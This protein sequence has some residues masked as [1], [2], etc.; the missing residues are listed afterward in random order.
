MIAELFGSCCYELVV[1]SDSL[2][3]GFELRLNFHNDVSDV[4]VQAFSCFEVFVK[5]EST[6]VVCC[7]QCVLEALFSWQC[8]DV[9]VEAFSTVEILFALEEFCSFMRLF[10]LG[11]S[12]ALYSRFVAQFDESSTVQLKDCVVTCMAQRFV[13]VK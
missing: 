6:S 8:V 2:Y 7:E 9:N 11:T 4:S 10:R 13:P 5:C 12:C 3:F 1:S